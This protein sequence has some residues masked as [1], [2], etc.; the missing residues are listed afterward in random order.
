VAVVVVMV[1]DTTIVAVVVARLTMDTTT[2]CHNVVAV[3]VVIE[4]AVAVAMFNRRFV[5]VGA[6]DTMMVVDEVVVVDTMMEEAEVVVDTMMEVV[7]VADTALGTGMVVDV[8]VVVV[9]IE[10]VVHHHPDHYLHQVVVVVDHQIVD[11]AR[12][13]RPMSLCSIPCT[14]NGSGLPNDV[15]NVKRESHGLMSRPK[16]WDCRLWHHY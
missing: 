11:D 15:A 7:E 5:R 4:V 13:Y 14:K 3:V 2:R 1:V 9:T 10:V 16:T 8:V 12:Q 6:A